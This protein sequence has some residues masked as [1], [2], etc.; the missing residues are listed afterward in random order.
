MDR[1]KLFAGSSGVMW[2]S[3]VDVQRGVFAI[4]NG[5]GAASAHDVAPGVSSVL[6]RELRGLA[7]LN[8]EDALDA[9]FHRAH[10]LALELVADGAWVTA[11][12][13]W[14]EEETATIAHVGD[15]SVYLLRGRGLVRQ[16][17]P[18]TLVNSLIRAGQLT[19]EDVPQFEYKNVLSRALGSTQELAV[20]VRTVPAHDGDI[21]VLTS[22]DVVDALGEDLLGRILL[23]WREPEETAKEIVDL[24]RKNGA[25]KCLGAVV[26][27][28]GTP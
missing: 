15:D 11:A 5:A 3:I 22:A 12:S 26:I 23:R 18:H 4:V 16:N 8:I 20:D 6:A 28:L 25:S 19:A 24:A 21:W 14:F 1:L 10:D 7:H 2:T 13:I 27:V 9:A 17:E